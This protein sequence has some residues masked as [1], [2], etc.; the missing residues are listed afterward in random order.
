MR[1][2][3]AVW[4]GMVGLWLLPLSLPAAEPPTPEAVIAHHVQALGSPRFAQRERATRAL[5]AVGE[6]A[7]KQLNEVARSG[8]PEVRARAR[9]VIE[10]IEKQLTN[11]RLLR[12]ATVRF[13]F[14][15]TPLD[16]AVAEVKKKTG[17]PLELDPGRVTDPKRPVT[18]DTGE[19]PVWEALD[20]FYAA[21]GLHESLLPPS[22]PV[23]G[24]PN[25]YANPYGEL[26]SPLG[27]YAS[28]IYG[29]PNKDPRVYLADG[30]SSPIPAQ[31]GGAVRV[32]ALPA[33]FFG[34]AATNGS[35]EVRFHLEVSPAPGLNWQE[36]VGVDIRRAVDDGG[37]ELAQ[38]YLQ[39]DGQDPNAMFINDGFGFQQQILIRRQIAVIDNS[40][41]LGPV[42][43]QHGNPRHVPVTLLTKDRRP[44]RLAELEGVISARV[45]SPPQP[46]VTVEHVLKADPKQ[47][48]EA[49]GQAVQILQAKKLDNGLITLRLRWE[50]N[51]DVTSTVFPV[52]VGGRAR[53]F[54]VLNE[55]MNAQPGSQFSLQDGT[56]KAFR[57]VTNNGISSSQTGNAAMHEMELTFQPQRGQGE[58]A[59]LVLTGTKPVVVEVPFALKNVPL[60]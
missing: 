7:L 59:K 33:N 34:N 49:D 52:R 23:A 13:T 57:L 19:L 46:L 32:R 4:A 42:G 55:A 12:A 21:A 8:D 15:D 20:R 18:V 58:A 44:R 17:L 29:L 26:E 14:K 43:P 25:P 22:K 53:P 36:V 5:E 40:V 45:I 3:L 9:H 16:R 35:G 30:K 41:Y 56:G 6:P 28:T 11:A 48:F 60:P 1:A 54:I 31:L 47:R 2:H 38:S 27:G 24:P 51:V 39:S 37:R 10:R 50:T